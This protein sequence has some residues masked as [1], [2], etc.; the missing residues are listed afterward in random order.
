MG[1]MMVKYRWDF[2]RTVFF[3]SN[4]ELFEMLNKRFDTIDGRLDKIETRLDNMDQR[5]DIL[6]EDIE[7]IKE[8]C[9]IT[10]DGTNHLGEWVEY[11]FG[12]I[13]PYPLDRDKANKEQSTLNLINVIEQQ[14]R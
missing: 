4:E 13:M 8:D 12:D 14:K 1:L 2:E 7:V 9:E 10:R 6:E 3:M 5:L 11:Y